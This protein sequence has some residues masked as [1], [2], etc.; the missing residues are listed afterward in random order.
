MPLHCWSYFSFEESVPAACI[1][2]LMQHYISQYWMLEVLTTSNNF[3][4]ASE[5][6]EI[7]HT[8]ESTLFYYSE[9]WFPTH[10][11]WTVSSCVNNRGFL[12][13][14]HRI[15]LLQAVEYGCDCGQRQL[16]G[17]Q[18]VALSISVFNISTIYSQV[19]SIQLT[20][21]VHCLATMSY[22]NYH[23]HWINGGA[24]LEINPSDGRPLKS[25]R[26][27]QHF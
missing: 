15:W 9:L 7:L 11:Y 24:Q 22:F 6:C 19:V 26:N 14:S 1:G 18:Q 3:S 16:A 5:R 8:Q 23:I 21:D 2:I 4:H 27:D 25:V 20:Y 13:E 17:V 10:F 12:L